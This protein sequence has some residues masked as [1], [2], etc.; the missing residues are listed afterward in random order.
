M[1]IKIESAKC[2]LKSSYRIIQEML[3]IESI[4]SYPEMEK[5][6]ENFEESE[7]L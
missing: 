5:L 6:E 3:E 1:E 7:I 4:R 2:R